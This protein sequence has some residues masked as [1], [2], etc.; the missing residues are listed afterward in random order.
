MYG[1]GVVFRASAVIIGR[2]K[3]VAHLYQYEREHIKNVLIAAVLTVLCGLCAV[4][5]VW[6]CLNP[7]SPVGLIS[8]EIQSDPRASDEMSQ[9]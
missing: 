6:Y 9:S 7:R 4:S 3:K 2:R 1:W 5:L 8:K